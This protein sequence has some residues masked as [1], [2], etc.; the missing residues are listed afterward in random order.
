MRLEGGCKRGG[1]IRVAECLRQI[2]PNRWASSRKRSFTKCLSFFLSKLTVFTGSIAVPLAVVKTNTVIPFV[3]LKK[4]THCGFHRLYL[5][6]RSS[7]PTSASQPQRTADHTAAWRQT[8]QCSLGSN[9][10]RS[11]YICAYIS[12]VALF[13]WLGWVGVL[14]VE[15]LY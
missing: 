1:R 8:Q 15:Q 12:G 5:C 9:E 4:N 11:C 2:V 7:F 3:E 6:R 14:A 13:A 10:V